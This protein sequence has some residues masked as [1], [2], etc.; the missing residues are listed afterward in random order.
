M[1]DIDS[2]LAPIS[3]ENPTGEYLKLDRSA[4]RALRNSYNT[5]QSSFRQLV[6]T[7]DASSDEALLDANSENWAQLRD[8]TFSA[9]TTATKDIE[10]LGWYITSQLFTTNP[11]GNLAK[12][13]KVLAQTAEIFWDTL[14]PT[15]PEKKIKSSDE[16]GKTKELIEFR[17]KPLLQLVGESQDSTA[18]Y[19]P[20][21]LVSLIDDI[22]FSDYLRAERSGELNQLKEKAQSLFSGDVEETLSHLAETYRNFSQAETIIAQHC[23]SHAVAAI[24]FKFVKANITDLINA[25]KYLV[26]DKFAFWPL[27]DN[28][29]LREPETQSASPQPSIAAAI[30]TAPQV[31]EPEQPAPV[32]ESSTTEPVVQTS[33]TEVQPAVTQ[34]VL[35]VPAGQIAT[36]DQAFHELRKISEYFKQTEPH[37]PI[38]F[39]LERAIRWGYMSLPELM[40]EMTGNNSSV[41]Q[42]INQLTGMDH[43]EQ[44]DLSGKPYV[45]P[46]ITT[47]APEISI[48]DAIPNTVPSNSINEQEVTETQ[49]PTQSEAETSSTSGSVTD[50]EW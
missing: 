28:Y 30:D 42:H 15:L 21:Q 6:E 14:H 20:L 39:L 9:L 18:L 43:L 45:E 5:A 12:S 17:I 13:T 19:M 33:V 47:P 29:A 1:V 16:A 35:A 27:D 22:S 2:L 38:S 37:S 10:L 8:A 11:Y 41:M 40:Q 24:S 32:E 34:T 31:S 23:Q 25:I 46:Q 44:Q 7:P 48:S 36:R 26:G 50:F 3:D 49:Q 4:Y